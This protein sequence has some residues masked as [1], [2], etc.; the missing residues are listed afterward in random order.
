MDNFLRMRRIPD[1]FNVIVRVP[2]LFL[3]DMICNSKRCVSLD[4]WLM[5]A[6]LINFILHI[7]VYLKSNVLM[8]HLPLPDFEDA[9]YFVWQTLGKQMYL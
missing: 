6:K 3:M 7:P 8:N 4:G 5:L 1:F 2:P 9:T